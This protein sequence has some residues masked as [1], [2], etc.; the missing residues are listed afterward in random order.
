MI[1]KNILTIVF[2]M[3]FLISFTSAFTPYPILNGTAMGSDL[4][5]ILVYTNTITGGWAILLMTIAFF[6]VVLLG[7][8]F[9]QL[10]FQGRIK[11]EVHFAASS[12]A[13]LGWCAILSTVNGLIS[14]TYFLIFIGL[15]IMSVL[16]LLLSSD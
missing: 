5:Y 4:S 9:M 13:T 14:P 16:W 12:F 11:F 8:M 1:N 15:S 2:G 6:M 3:I 7:S 10:R